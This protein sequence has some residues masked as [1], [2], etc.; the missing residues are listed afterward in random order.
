[1][2]K[3][4]YKAIN[5]GGKEVT[6]AIDA[7]STQDAISRV[8]AKG[9]YPTQITQAQADEA[10]PAQQAQAPAQQAQ[11]PA[12]APAK[13]KGLS[14]EVSIPFL[15]IGTVST[16]EVAIFT[17]Q[18][19]TLIDAGLPLVRS[20]NV[21]HDQLKVG[22]LRDII[23]NLSKEVSAGG[24]LSEALAKYPKVFTSLYV[25]MIRAGEAGGVLEIVL[26]RLA[27][28][29]EKNL[30]LQRRIK[31]ALIY[32]AL[33]V[34][35][36]VGVLAFLVIYLIP[37]FTEIFENMD[38][39]ELP[40]PTKMV[41]GISSLFKENA[42][43]GII[44]LVL[45][46]VAYVV[47]SKFKNFKLVMD[48]IKLRLPVFGELTRK[49]EVSRFS[50]TLGT[51]ISSGVP[52]LQALRITRGT[53][54]NELVSRSLGQVHDSIREG[55]SIAG[56]LKAAGI[57]PLMVVNMIDVG[58]ETGSLDSMLIKVADIYEEE[59]D[60]T[61]EALTSILEPFLI[62]T[63]GLIVGFIVISMFLP[64]IKLMTQIG[65]RA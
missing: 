7:D 4:Q 20:L 51:L 64:L 3:F 48:K 23:E 55:E 61:V 47:L 53:M 43:I 31:A 28:F 24:T 29:M 63:M 41:L 17:R 13:K 22:P 25:N 18:L 65:Q 30:G 58:E 46:I 2:P 15:G 62:I 21:L 32:P 6:G 27:E 56:P 26:E 16:Q 50:R 19:A 34:I 9:L 40:W 11:A 54:D 12:A 60:A 57:F 59:V 37:K 10:A 44:I 38:I 5:S 35:F 39:G 14:K 45:L 1:M 36:A 33:V 42:L 52:I 8:K 49:I